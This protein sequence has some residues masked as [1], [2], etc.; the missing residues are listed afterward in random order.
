[1]CQI[2]DQ[3]IIIVSCSK[4]T[5]F[6]SKKHIEI[7]RKNKEEIEEVYDNASAFMHRII[8]TNS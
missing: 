4:N 3:R 8:K 1:M 7:N 6:N 2:Q 5:L